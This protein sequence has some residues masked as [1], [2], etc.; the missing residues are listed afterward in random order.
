[1]I[2]PE[3]LRARTQPNGTGQQSPPPRPLLTQLRP[4]LVG[5]AAI[6]IIAALYWA[7]SVLIPV[8]LALL[9]AFLLG[10]P[11]R[12][13]QR[14]GLGST[15]AGRVLSVILVVALVF[16]LLGGISYVIARQIVALTQELPKYRGNLKQKIADL[17]GVGKPAPLKEMESTA[18]EVIGEL[19]KHQLPKRKPE[20]VPVTVTS[21]PLAFWRLPRLL[22]ALTSA[23]FVIV[24]VVFM[25]IERQD[26]RNRLIRLIGY[27]RVVVTTRALDDASDRITRYLLF[28]TI[29][30]LTYG[31][32]IGAGLFFIGVPYVV[33]WGFLAFALRFVPYVGPW[34]AALAPLALSLAVFADWQRPLLAAGLFLAVEALTY[35]VIE[36]FVYR[37]ALGLSQTAL[38]VAL[39]FWT[40]LWGPIGLLLATPLTVCLVVL[41]KH[42]SALEF[43]TILMTDDEPT[44]ESDVAYYQ[45][46]LARD[47]GEAND[48][49]DAYLRAHTLEEA[50]DDILIPALAYAKRDRE[51]EQVTEDEV[52]AI[53]GATMETITHLDSTA[54]TDGVSET[55]VAPPMPAAAVLGCAAGDEAG[56]LALRMLQQLLRPHA[57]GLQVGSARALTSEVLALVAEKNPSIVCIASIHPDDLAQTRHL[58]KRL[59]ARFPAL[60]ILVGRWG[61][62]APRERD[63]L[64]A[65]FADAVGSTLRESRDQIRENA[66][67]D[68]LAPAGPSPG[69]SAGH[70]LPEIAAPIGHPGPLRAR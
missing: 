45:R 31:V 56:E 40:W 58:C 24:L 22:E 47:Q 51:K 64:L 28:Q 70:E 52:Q 57:V 63:Q 25:L 13:L 44:L 66:R 61:P 4:Y 39:A 36:P 62:T 41:G 16:S 34:L 33:L 5:A 67:L 18:N 32:A 65:S 26:L 43:F 8:A 68:A 53:Y 11:V 23:G 3:A 20:P 54:G 12:A 42:V 60:K 27:E 37:Q 2:P 35:M 21:E 50:Y 49:V 29:I 10:P 9:F 59:R 1:M 38:L 14:T 30:N 55:G 15:R 46:V 48:I 17:R 6:P 19:Q 7:Q 69:A